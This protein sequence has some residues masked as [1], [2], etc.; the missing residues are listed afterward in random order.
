MDDKLVKHR[1]IYKDLVYSSRPRSEYQL[2]PNA[3]I[4]MALAPE[5]FTPIY[6]FKHLAKTE[7][8]LIEPNSLGI[9]TLD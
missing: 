1:G 8:L 2:R 4:A 7:L 9:K 5:L 3:C 6:A